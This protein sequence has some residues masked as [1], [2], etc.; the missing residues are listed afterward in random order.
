LP[1]DRRTDVNLALQALWL[2]RV[3]PDSFVQLRHQKLVWRDRVQPRPSCVPY[4]VQ[5]R[6]EPVKVA[7][8]VLDP[9]LVPNQ[10]GQLPHVYDDGS[11]CVARPKDWH[12]GMLFVDTFVPW[13]LEWLFY[14]ELWRAT[15]MWMGDGRDRMEDTAQSQILH[16]YTGRRPLQPGS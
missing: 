4:L 1:A 12:R 16:P 2:K 13:A 10:A 8:H 5:L 6:A 15:D 9:A 3:F 11:L 7:L 14:Y